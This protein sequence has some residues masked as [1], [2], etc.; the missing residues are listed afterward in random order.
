M[1]LTPTTTRSTKLAPA[2]TF[3]L[4]QLGLSTL[5][6][7]DQPRTAFG[8]EPRFGTDFKVFKPDFD[9]DSRPSFFA[10]ISSTRA[11]F[12]QD[13]STNHTYQIRFDNS[14]SPPA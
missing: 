3:G 1:L 6:W 12:V 9:A 11:D 7:S 4:G 13:L 10:L 2:A 5:A 8:A 14:S